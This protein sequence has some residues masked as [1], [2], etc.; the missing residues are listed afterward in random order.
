MRQVGSGEKASRAE[1]VVRIHER[2]DAVDHAH[3]VALELDEYLE[4]GLHAVERRAHVEAPDRDI[5][6]PEE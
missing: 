3:T 4:S 2:F 1:L 6:G 5:V